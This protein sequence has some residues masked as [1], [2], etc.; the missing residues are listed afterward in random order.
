MSKTPALVGEASLVGR[1]VHVGQPQNDRP[2]AALALAAR[3]R[4]I[5][6]RDDARASMRYT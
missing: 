5:L 4:A 2:Q 3:W 6:S 1:V